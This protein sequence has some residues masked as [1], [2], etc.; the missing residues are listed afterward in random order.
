VH[1][2]VNELKIIYSG[3]ISWGKTFM[4]YLQIDLFLRDDTVS[5]IDFGQ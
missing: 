1:P 2:D 4:D 5:G 3:L